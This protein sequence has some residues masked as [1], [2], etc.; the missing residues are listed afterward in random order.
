LNGERGKRREKTN[1]R[2]GLSGLIATKSQK[3]KEN[4]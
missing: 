2:I 3:K 1:R 4:Q